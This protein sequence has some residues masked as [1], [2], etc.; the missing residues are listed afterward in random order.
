M[1]HPAKTNPTTRAIAAAIIWANYDTIPDALPEHIYAPHLD[2]LADDY[3]E[4]VDKVI[5]LM[6]TNDLGE[7]CLAD[8]WPNVEGTYTLARLGLTDMQGELNPVTT[9]FKA[10]TEAQHLLRQQGILTNGVGV[11]DN[12][13]KLL[14]FLLDS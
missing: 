12:N 3:Y 11:D 9:E 5:D 13:Y 14:D 8:L 4:W 2:R 1:T 7:L 10:A 6:I